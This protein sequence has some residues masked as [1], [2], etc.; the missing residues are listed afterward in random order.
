MNLTTALKIPNDI[1][2]YEYNRYILS[3]RDIV[4]LE[5]T[6]SMLS[7]ADNMVFC[8]FTFK[9]EEDRKTWEAYL[10]EDIRRFIINE[11]I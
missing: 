2:D 9:T 8:Y 4:G 3:T 11:V 5:K 10:P 6:E 1:L 7:I